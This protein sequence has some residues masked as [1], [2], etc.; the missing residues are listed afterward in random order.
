MQEF[1]YEPQID[2]LITEDDAPLDIFVSKQHHLLIESLYASWPSANSGRRFLACANVGV[3]SVARNPAIVPNVFVSLDVE[4]PQDLHAK[5]NRAYFLWEFGKPPDIVIEIVFGKGEELVRSNLKQYER[6]KV[7]YVVIFD[8]RRQMQEAAITIYR[9]QGLHY[10]LAESAVLLPGKLG[11]AEWQGQ[12][13]GINAAWLRWTDGS[14]NLLLTGKESAD[15]L[16][17]ERR[18]R[19]RQLGQDPDQV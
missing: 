9:L 17:A 14:G 5:R 10:Q 1:S 18:L 8:P 12:F 3:F 6:M 16:A 19:E 2:H 4:L 11:L 7:A 15:Q 13:E